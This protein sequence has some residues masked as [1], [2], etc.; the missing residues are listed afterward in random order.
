MPSD[1]DQPSTPSSTFNLVQI[2]HHFLVYAH[3]FVHVDPGQASLQIA[4]PTNH[5]YKKAQKAQENWA[6]LLAEPGYLRMVA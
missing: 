4:S 6:N 2:A 5:E 3:R 1:W